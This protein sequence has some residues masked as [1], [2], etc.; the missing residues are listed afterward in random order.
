MEVVV[1]VV[2]VVRVKQSKNSTA[3]ATFSAMHGSQKAPSTRHVP[4]GKRGS[5]WCFTL[6]C[7]ST[8][9]DIAIFRRRLGIAGLPLDRLPQLLRCLLLLARS[10]IPSTTHPLT[11]THTYIDRFTR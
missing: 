7:S 5:S 4:R 6:E 8:R 2:R 3:E 9:Y 10:C 1:R 11:L